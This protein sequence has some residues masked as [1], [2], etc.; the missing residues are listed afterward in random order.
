MK[1]FEISALRVAYASI[2]FATCFKD[3]CRYLLLSCSLTDSPNTVFKC[4]FMCAYA[5]DR[6]SEP[7]VA[8]FVSALLMPLHTEVTMIAQHQIWYRRRRIRTTSDD[9]KLPCIAIATFL[10]QP[11]LIMST[12]E[13]Q[14]SCFIADALFFLFLLSFFI[15]FHFHTG[16]CAHF[17]SLEI[18]AIDLKLLYT[19]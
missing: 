4:R 12:L 13:T 15:L 14:T 1:R 3:K 19:V 10:V 16:I 18:S 8:C 2:I 5:T 7:F 17:S 11:T 9:L 6:T